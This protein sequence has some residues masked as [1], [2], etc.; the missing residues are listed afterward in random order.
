MLKI[1][2]NDPCPCGSGKKF[3]KCHLGR[4]EDLVLEKLDTLPDGAAQS[5]AALPEV[6]YGR[7]RE[8]VEDLDWEAL[9]GTKVGVKFVDLAS[10]LDLNIVKRDEHKNLNRVS[11]GQMINPMKTMEADSKHIYIAVSPAVSD[12][13]LI[14]QLAHALDYLA[15]SRNN[16][17]LAG[18]LSMEL[19]IPLEL[20]EHPKEFGDWLQFLK[21][22]FNVEL[23]AEDTIV[24]FLHE[25]GHLLPGEAIGEDDN[26]MIEVHARRTLDFIRRSRREID[27]R[28][29]DR[30]GYLGTPQPAGDG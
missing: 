8:M 18:P 3:K 14:H 19:D 1:G 21:N 13:T 6:K 27:Q 22:E 29:K 16:P 7:C 4:E 30:E 17:A 20:L 11:A 9:T 23:D 10:Y 24:S 28:I 25:T 5:I 26:T 2:R 12:S 15:G